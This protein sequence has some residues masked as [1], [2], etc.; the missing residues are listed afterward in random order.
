QD[1]D[2]R[3]ADLPAVGEAEDLLG[4]FDPVDAGHAHVHEDDIVLLLADGVD[5]GHAIAGLTGHGHIGLGVDDHGEAGAHK[6]L[7]VDEDDTQRIRRMSS[8]RRPPS[9][10]LGALG[11]DA[12]ASPSAAAEPAY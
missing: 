1:D 5:A 12:A 6:G 3:G 2:L 7:V 11:P 10:P 4:R 8:H 9:S